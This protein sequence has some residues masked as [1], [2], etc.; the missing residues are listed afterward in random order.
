MRGK[1]K[2]LW[3]RHLDRKPWIF[4]DQFGLAYL[5]TAQDNV[6]EYCEQSAVVDNPSFLAWLQATVKPGQLF[7]DLSPVIGGV[8]MLA[9]RQVQDTGAVFAFAPE[10]STYRQLVNNV[11]LNSLT[12]SVRVIGRE[13][14][15]TGAMDRFAAEWQWPTVDYLRLK[16]IGHINAL[17]TSAASLFKAGRIRHLLL[18]DVE[19][20]AWEKVRSS[21]AGLGFVPQLLSHEGELQPATGAQITGKVNVI[22]TRPEAGHA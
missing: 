21:L 20:A 2:E 6:A 18:D 9:G 19:Q 12:G 13:V 10:A 8:T 15:S 17:Q 16:D 14:L 7:V 22:A 4:R 3:H 11:A 5:F 1:L